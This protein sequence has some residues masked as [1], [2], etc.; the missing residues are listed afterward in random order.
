MIDDQRHGLTERNEI[1]EKPFR[2][3]NERTSIQD[4]SLRHFDDLQPISAPR[5]P[6]TIIEHR[7]NFMFYP[8]SSR[9]IISFPPF[10]PGG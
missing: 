9:G 10:S 8:Q 1:S 6:R 5:R 3:D 2:G 4:L 7:C